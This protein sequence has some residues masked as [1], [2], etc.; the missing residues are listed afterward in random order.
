MGRELHGVSRLSGVP[1]RT[2]LQIEPQNNARR[3]ADC[4]DFGARRGGRS[5]RHSWL[6]STFH[7][8][9]R[10]FRLQMRCL[11][12]KYKI[13]WFVVDIPHRERYFFICGSLTD[14][15]GN[16]SHEPR[17][18]R[19]IEVRMVALSRLCFPAE[20]SRCARERPKTST[21]PHCAG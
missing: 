20:F 17:Q 14:C 2:T 6:F 8:Q 15:N 5:P 13:L 11:T 21:R 16:G 18:R 12:L 4:N 1:M 19:S 10:L 7:R 9:M 3:S